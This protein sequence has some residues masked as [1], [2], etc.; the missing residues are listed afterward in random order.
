VPDLI[1]VDAVTGFVIVAL[2][3]LPYLG[4]VAGACSARAHGIRALGPG[5]VTTLLL[6][7]VGLPSVV[8]LLAP[9]VLRALRRDAD[10]IASGQV[11][12]LVTALLQQDGGVAGTVSNLVALLFIGSVAEHLL[13]GVRTVVCFFGA[14]V[15]AELPALAWQPVGAGNSVANFGLAGAV[16]VHVLLTERRSALAVTAAAL[17]LLVGVGLTAL[18]N[19]HGP[20]VLLG[21]VAGLSTL[22]LVRRATGPAGP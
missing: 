18:A 15:L 11:W 14:G 10:R 8:G 21:A 19:L 5:P 3:L 7:V 17:T 9:T 16:A 22:R 4:V 20:A 1:S 6:L 2:L 13:G 12:R